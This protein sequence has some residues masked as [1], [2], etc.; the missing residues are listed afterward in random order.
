MK[1]LKIEY[2]TDTGKEV[3]LFDADVTEVS[4]ADTAAGVRVEG[5]TAPAAGAA[6]NPG[7]SLLEA[8]AGAARSRNGAAIEEKKAELQREKEEGGRKAAGRDEAVVEEI[9]GAGDS[10]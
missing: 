5:K 10:A 4:W 1:H 2:T 9:V 7:I 6:G 8:L 3:T